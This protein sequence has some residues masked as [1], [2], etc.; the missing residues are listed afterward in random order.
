[1]RQRLG[2]GAPLRTRPRP[3]ARGGGVADGPRRH[4][5]PPAVA[6]DGRRRRLRGGGPA[7]PV[8]GPS[9]GTARG[10]VT[11]AAAASAASTAPAAAAGAA[12][13]SR[14]I[15]MATANAGA[16]ATKSVQ[17]PRG[18]RPPACRCRWQ[19]RH[20]RPTGGGWWR[21]RRPVGSVA[22]TAAVALTA[23]AAVAA[24]G[25]AVAITFSV[26]AA[27]PSVSTQKWRRHR[28]PRVP[29]HVHK[30]AHQRRGLPVGQLAP[31]PDAAEAA[32]AGVA[33][34]A[35]VAAAAA[36]AVAATAADAAGCLP[37]GYGRGGARRVAA[38]VEHRDGKE[39]GGAAAKRRHRRRRHR[40]HPVC[41]TGRRELRT[42]TS[43]M[44][45]GVEGVGNE[46]VDVTSLGE[47]KSE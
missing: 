37:A 22:A 18:A 30:D 40:R 2:G 44:G 35:E 19:R 13:A 25:V 24:D 33:A 45:G 28:P 23:T 1:M 9:T 4:W 29:P 5:R 39:D 16:V 47:Q 31:A 46:V 38:R 11:A 17:P 36:T 10:T 41:A 21:H 20:A 8:A 12:T 34:S 27:H 3:Q 14:A 6:G 43:V 15:P 7:G 32:A 26:P 42:G